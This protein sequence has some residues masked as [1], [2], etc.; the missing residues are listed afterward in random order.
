M[1]KPMLACNITNLDSIKFPIFCSPKIDGIRCL[2]IDGKVLSRTLKP[3][4]NKYIQSQLA[5]FPTNLDGELYIQGKTCNEISSAVMSE[6][7]EPD[8]I[9]CVFDHITEKPYCKRLPSGYYPTRVQFVPRLLV[10]NVEVV[11]ELEAEYLAAGYEGL[12]IRAEYGPYKYGRSTEKEGF[13]MK[14]KRFEDSEA[15]ILEI[16]PEYENTNTQV[17]NE[18]GKKKRSSHK[19]NKVKKEMCGALIVKDLY[20]GVE[21][22]VSSG[23]DHDLKKDIWFNQDSYKS[24]IVKYKYMD[25][26]KNKPRHPTFLGFRHKEDLTT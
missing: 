21:F 17:I 16:L 19:A 5:N 10:P 24:K 7:G 3:I 11:L 2:I 26:L 9:Y 4:P 20:T 22:K 23:L 13:L 18:L 8:F 12:I 25:T 1:F 6:E 14:L 15:E